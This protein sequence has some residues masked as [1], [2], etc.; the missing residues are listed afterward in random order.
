[1]ISF[2]LGQLEG[3]LYPFI[4]GEFHQRPSLP[5]LFPSSYIPLD[6]LILVGQYSTLRD[7]GTLARVVSFEMLV[8][9]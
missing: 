9:F 6:K 8:I 7:A 2:F 4:L 1:M 5:Q 3:D